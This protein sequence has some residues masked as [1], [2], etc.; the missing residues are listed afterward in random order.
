MLDRIWAMLQRQRLRRPPALQMA[1]SLGRSRRSR[2]RAVLSVVLG[3][4]HVAPR[5][6]RDWHRQS[7]TERTFRT[8]EHLPATEANSSSRSQ[9]CLFFRCLDHLFLIVQ[10]DLDHRGLLLVLQW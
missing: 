8:L 1:Q 10:G 3:N 5:L 6:I 9:L 4:S 2:S 7:D